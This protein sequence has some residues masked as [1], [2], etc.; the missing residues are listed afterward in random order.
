M[1]RDYFTLF[2][3]NVCGGRAIKSV[4]GVPRETWAAGIGELAP[5]ANALVMSQGVV[6]TFLC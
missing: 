2:F 4:S 1:I 5:R 3:G 6:R